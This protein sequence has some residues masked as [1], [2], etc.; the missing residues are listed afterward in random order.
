MEGRPEHTE[1]SSEY[2]EGHPEHTKTSPEHMEGLP[3]LMEALTAVAG[4]NAA[5]RG[6]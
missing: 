4:M 3:A 1:A 2:V 5:I 6:L